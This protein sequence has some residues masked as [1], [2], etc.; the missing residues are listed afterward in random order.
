M[1][2]TIQLLRQV[3]QLKEVDVE[4][5]SPEE[6]CRLA[7]EANPPRLENDDGWDDNADKDSWVL[8]TAQRPNYTHVNDNYCWDN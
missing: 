5:A 6:A 7:L 1:R 3:W 2:Y 4:A 8:D